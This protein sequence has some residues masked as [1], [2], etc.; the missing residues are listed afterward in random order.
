MIL[1]RIGYLMIIFGFL[2]GSILFFDINRWISILSLIILFI[3][4]PYCYVGVM[5]DSIGI[6]NPSAVYQRYRNNEYPK[7][8]PFFQWWYYSLKDYKSD[9]TFAFCY[10]MSRPVKDPKN[11]GAYA[12]FALVEKGRKFHI[13]YK[14]PLEKF[15]AKNHFNVNIA[16]DLFKIDVISDDH[17]KLK[18]KMMNPE[19]VYVAEGVHE[20]VEIEWDIDIKRIVGWYGQKDIEYLTKLTETISWNTYAYDSEVWGKIKI[21]GQEYLIERNENFRIYCDMNWGAYFPSVKSPKKSQIEYPWGWYYTGI[22]NSDPKNDFSIIAGVGRMEPR[23]KIL[24]IMNAKFASI[25]LKGNKIDARFGTVFNSK[26]DRGFTFFH[27]SMDGTT[28]KFK[29]ERSNWVEYKDK[30]GSAQIPLEQT[31]IIETKSKRII[32]RYK[33]TIENYNRLLFPTDGYVFSDFEGLGVTCI[34][35]IY[36]KQRNKQFKLVE[37]YE[38]RNA[39]LEYGYKLDIDL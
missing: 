35:E 4:T 7:N 15:I 39:G 16:D 8:K 34:T 12:T 27:P 20:N 29:V 19:S 21:D 25:Y 10:S 24:G 37:K 22:P 33:S 30:F 1:K 26:E 3:F 9:R 5:T 28:K 36:E 23:F 17:L 14:F 18:G 38:D 13:Y 6:W 31:V 32:M 2:T 11:T